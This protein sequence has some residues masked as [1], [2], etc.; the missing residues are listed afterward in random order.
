MLFGEEQ[1]AAYVGFVMVD[2]VQ[3]WRGH[4]ERPLRWKAVVQ[5][6]VHGKQVHVVHGYVVCL[7][8]T[9]QIAHVNEGGSV[10]TLRDGRT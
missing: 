1:D 3:L 4:M 6:L 8:S 9:L 2:G 10:E 5:G 7:I